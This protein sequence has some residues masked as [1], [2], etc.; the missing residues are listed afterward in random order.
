MLH[1]MLR[2]SQTPGSMRIV[3]LWP[4]QINRTS[5]PFR[6]LSHGHVPA[7]ALRSGLSVT[8]RRRVSPERHRRTVTLKAAIRPVRSKAEAGL[9]GLAH[10]DIDTISVRA[11]PQTLSTK[12]AQ[13][14]LSSLPQRM[15]AQSPSTTFAVVAASVTKGG[16]RAFAA[17]ARQPTSVHQGTLSVFG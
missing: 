5:L 6:L 4:G 12:S 15:A 17:A 13:S 9:I 10:P 11:L 2:K 14:R 16:E 8:G 3:A 7:L 1:D